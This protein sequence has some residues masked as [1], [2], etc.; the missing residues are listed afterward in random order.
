M[1]GIAGYFQGVRKEVL[2]FQVMW[3]S[4]AEVVFGK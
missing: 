3:T 2:C 4:P 1:E